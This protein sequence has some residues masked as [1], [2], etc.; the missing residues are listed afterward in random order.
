[1]RCFEMQPQVSIVN[2][3]RNL[4]EPMEMIKHERVVIYKYLSVT[5]R[6]TVVAY[7]PCGHV[8]AMVREFVEPAV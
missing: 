7:V 2:M 4:L 6:K 1:M 3:R 5:Q 8:G